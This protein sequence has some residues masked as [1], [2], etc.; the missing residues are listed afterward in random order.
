MEPLEHHDLTIFASMTSRRHYCNT[1]IL[2]ENAGGRHLSNVDESKSPLKPDT[3]SIDNDC[4]GDGLTASGKRSREEKGSLSGTFSSN[5][6]QRVTGWKSKRRPV[7]SNSKR[8]PI[9]R[10]KVSVT[11]SSLFTTSPLLSPSSLPCGRL[12]VLLVKWMKEGKNEAKIHDHYQSSPMQ[13]N[14]INSSLEN[15]RDG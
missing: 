3:R 7:L 8:L 14:T 10:I 13:S 1:Q 12:I 15:G 5:D 6:G 4:R 9:S 2:G 11:T